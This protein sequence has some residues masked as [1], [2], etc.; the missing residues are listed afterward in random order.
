MKINERCQLFFKLQ[1]IAHHILNMFLNGEDL[2]RT[3]KIFYPIYS[4]INISTHIKIK[5]CLDL[6]RNA[7]K[8]VN[9]DFKDSIYVIEQKIKN[10][11]TI[12]SVTNIISQLYKDLDINF[13]KLDMHLETQKIIIGEEVGSFTAE[14][15][16]K[17]GLA[18]IVW[19]KKIIEESCK[20]EVLEFIIH[21]SFSTLDFN[22]G[23]SDIDLLAIIRKEIINDPLKLISL[24]AKLNEIL[25]YIYFIDPFQH[26]GISVLSE[27][28][29]NF[30][31]QSYFP[32]IIYKYSK[33]LI[34][35][36][37]S[38]LQIKERTS[39]YERVEA[40]YGIINF[41]KNTEYKIA[42]EGLYRLKF[43]LSAL[44]LLPCI[45]L[46]LRGDYM[47]KKYSF[48]KIKEG[49]P[50]DFWDIFK[51]ATLLRETWPIR[52]SNYKWFIKIPKINPN[53]FM[54]PIYYRIF[55]N[56]IPKY[57]LNMFN[58]DYFRKTKIFLD[59]IS[60]KA[61]NEGYLNG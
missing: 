21:G 30:Y 6:L 42:T 28:D 49:I 59:F 27:F 10:N 8:Q 11:L 4:Q 23:F 15:Y 9:L 3:A 44:M 32:L 35:K 34:N 2:T 50:D 19:I 16:A 7:E 5:E 39:Y 51:K 20:F 41:L 47:Y 43:Y 38:I 1:N 17:M 40:F 52:N 26:H 61:K 46:Q 54:I 37:S 31:P 25:K 45:F 36:N 13:N 55:K 57:C 53:P 22:R 33:S 60:Q 48:N 58:Y 24:R 14:N 12:N 29:L 18:S 56:C